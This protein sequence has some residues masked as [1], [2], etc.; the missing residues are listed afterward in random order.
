MRECVR[1]REIV[2]MQ[3]MRGNNTRIDLFDAQLHFQ[4]VVKFQQDANISEISSR[5]KT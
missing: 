4:T 5:F 3:A 2:N 1:E